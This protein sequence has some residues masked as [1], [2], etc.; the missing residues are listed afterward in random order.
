MAEKSDRGRSQD[1]GKV[2]GGQKHEVSY[3]A[4]KTG[5]KPTEVR[6]AV[7]KAGNARGKV[8]AELKKAKQ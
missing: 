4:E 6:A 2:A 8:E 1:R 5:S 3:E 7:K